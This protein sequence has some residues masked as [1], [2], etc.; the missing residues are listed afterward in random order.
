MSEK[1]I[2]TADAYR[3][4]F[5]AIEQAPECS[6]SRA[7]QLFRT[8]ADE[9]PFD[10]SIYLS[11]AIT[12]GGYA[13]DEALAFPKVLTKNTAHGELISDVV[14]QQFSSIGIKKS[15]IV[16]PAT[17]GKVAGWG[18]AD[19]LLFWAHVIAG[20]EPAE[21]DSIDRAVRKSGVIE[22]PGFYDKNIDKQNRWVDYKELIDCYVDQL[23]QLPVPLYPKNIQSMILILDPE[24]SLGVNAERY[25]CHLLGLGEYAFG[26]ESYYGVT[27]KLNM[28]RNLGAST[29]ARGNHIFGRQNLITALR[30]RQTGQYFRKSGILGIVD[31]RSAEAQKIGVDSQRTPDSRSSAEQWADYYGDVLVAGNHE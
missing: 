1:L 29:L 9:H 10:P 5:E 14:A 26:V 25:L 18:Q 12:S 19:Y 2:R 28:V 8:F 13:R 20:V 3:P 17:L 6:T 31:R 21:A 23:D 30:R 16:T 11:M 27:A 7:Y 15:D 24:E 22:R 4:V